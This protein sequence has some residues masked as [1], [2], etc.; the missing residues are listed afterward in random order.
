MS[1]GLVGV[2]D[3]SQEFLDLG[4]QLLGGGKGDVPPAML[5]D[6]EL[7]CG[8]SR[9]KTVVAHLALGVEVVA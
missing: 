4:Q 5:L 7:E 2:L 3:D 8:L 1:V 6:L 9:S